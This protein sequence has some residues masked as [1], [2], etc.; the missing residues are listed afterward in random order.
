MARSG[1]T[2]VELAIVLVI[3]GLLIGGVLVGRDL[4]K[5]AT[6]KNFTAT[7]EKYNAGANTFRIKYRALP[8]DLRVTEAELYGFTPRTGQPG[9]GDGNGVI[10]GCALT[11][12]RLGCETALFWRDMWQ[13]HASPY[14]TIVATNVPVNGTAGGFTIDQYLPGTPFRSGTSVYM[15]AFNS[16]NSYYVARITAVASDGTMTLGPALTPQEARDIDDKM[17]DSAP[18]NGII[19]AMS[20]LV[21]YDAG[22]VPANGVCVNNTLASLAYNLIDRYSSNVSC[23]ITIRGSL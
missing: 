16:R 6:V 20:D 8:G 19:R 10:E 14:S 11:S 9:Q 4:I 18:A 7:I 22:A 23:M 17:D 2:L 15:Y 12:V 3:I 1:F 21:T 13:G 5:A